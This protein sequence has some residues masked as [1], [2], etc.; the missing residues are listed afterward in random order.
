MRF[1]ILGS[2]E[3]CGSE[4]LPVPLNAPK[5]RVL[6]TVLLLHANQPVSRRRL[7]AALWPDRAPPSAGGIIR[8]YASGLRQAA[9]LGDRG[10]L[11]HLAT[12]PGGYQL[13]LEPS[14]LDL[15]LFDDLTR[16]GR[17]A[18]GAR[19]AARSAQLLSEALALWRGEPAE[20]ITLD[21]DTMVL[22]TGLAERRLA[23]EE[24]WA[25]ARLELGG[26]AELVARLQ[27]IVAE[28]PLR[29]RTC[30]QLMLALHLAGRTS[31]ALDAFRTLRRRM[32]TELG[33]EPSAPLQELHRQILAGD[34]ALTRAPAVSRGPTAH[35]VVPRQLPPAVA[36]FTGRDA[37][38]E[39]LHSLDPA[40][41][42]VTIGG[43]AGAGKT[44][45][46][47][48]FG[49]QVADRFPDGQLF[50]DLL[51][52]AEDMPI[53][54]LRVLHRFLRA[55]GTAPDGVP[56][57]LT[58]ASALYRS[59]LAGKRMLIVLDNAASAS[60]VRNLLPGSSGCL[61]L[62]TS[63]SRLPGLVAKDGAVP[64]LVK[65]LG[66]TE[67]V[68]LLAKIIGAAR[69]DAELEAATVIAAS[70]AGLPLALRIA[71]ERAA[72]RPGLG[73][74]WLA[75]ELATERRRLDALTLGTD[76][77]TTVRSVF[78]W[79][80]RALAV[81]ARRMFRLL[82]LSPGPDI[83]IPAAAAL[84]RTGTE[85]TARLLE[86]LADV[87]LLDEVAPGG[88][89]RFHDLLRTYA[90]ECAE[91]DESPADRAAARR[92]ILTWYLNTADAADHL[93][94]PG[95]LHAPIDP[96]PPHCDPLG[97]ANYEQ[98]LAWCDAEHANLIAAAH[99]A[100]AEGYDDIAWKFPVALR[101]FFDVRRPFA[102]W[103]AC[104]R[105]GLAA[106]RRAADRPGEAWTLSC[107]AAVHS[108]MGRFAD[109]LRCNQE[110]LEI[111][112]QTGD[113]RREGAALNNIGTDYLGLRRYRAA[114]RCF[115][116]V[117]ENSRTDGSKYGAGI[118]LTNLGY[119]YHQMERYDDAVAAYQLALVAYRE[120]GYRQA[121]A[122]TL[123][124]LGMTYRMAS[125]LEAAR[126][127]Y[128]QALNMHRQ[129]GDRHGEAATHRDLGDLLHGTGAT[130]EARESWRRALTLF[131]D[132][133]D[134]RAEDVQK[135]LVEQMTVR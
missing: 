9:E 124:D 49:H 81:A 57:D 132:L 41:I 63:R 34:P 65:A 23:A 87:H 29:E 45:L 52:H 131:L 70:C 77:D 48:R 110:A 97:F 6:L 44:A 125:R 58:E 69:V 91:A 26:D 79:S 99:S 16:Q 104:A 109:A 66:E 21:S 12:V 53:D 5:Q 33:I 17:R 64:V 68:L 86:V 113:R 59:L 80:Y 25:D 1:R 22:L 92:R 94:V 115:E 67:G 28:Q 100:A 126:S 55:M 11:P 31:E 107:L 30:W 93:L 36:D 39:Q 90:A 127:C 73:L 38:L 116:A 62:V 98:A 18:L 50:A 4:G 32:V 106:A 3:V 103:M 133:G 88:R 60:Q 2:L 42:V 128:E 114:L 122:N 74:A 120:L 101:G 108:E 56:A 119:T 84:A 24:A 15:T 95:R 123:T 40:V 35:S 47:I 61:V 96:P 10:R 85:E 102:D 121:E 83:S 37:Q 27:V 8:T 14:D 20:D 43:A 117:L 134:S 129:A 13:V 72:L 7:A 111:Y 75:N 89:Y 19:D 76:T 78:S 135:R 71:A 82:G 51:G 105:D 54:P 118:A 130:A 112:R 46:A